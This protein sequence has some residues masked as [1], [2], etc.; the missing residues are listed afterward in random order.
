MTACRLRIAGRCVIVAA[1][2]ALFAETGYAAT[3]LEAVAARADVAVETVYKRFGSKSAL[4]SAILE[5]A[6]TGTENELDLLDQPLIG[7]VRSATEQRQQIRLLARFSR[8]ILERTAP[9]HR[10]LRSAA[11]VDPL[12]SAA[13]AADGERRRATQAAYIDLLL[14]N[15]P[16]RPGLERATAAD[17]YSVLANPATFEL[18]V[19]E[20]GWSSQKYEQ[21]L[22]DTLALLL[23]GP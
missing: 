3:T 17:T 18:L 16:L 8:S 22:G 1:A 21:W 9:T 10:I 11:A 12:A 5:P 7:E 19:G 15:G 2:T 4:L 23:L 13:Q 6:I 20:R 14:A